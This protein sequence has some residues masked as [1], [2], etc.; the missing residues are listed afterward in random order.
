MDN[1]FKNKK[2][3]YESDNLKKKEVLQKI[4]WSTKYFE[5]TTVN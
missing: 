3:N 4:D 2:S 5:E 1:I